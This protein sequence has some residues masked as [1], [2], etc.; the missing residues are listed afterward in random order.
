ML[1]AWWNCICPGVRDVTTRIKELLKRPKIKDMYA[2]G[3]ALKA[4]IDNNPNALQ[5]AIHALLEGSSGYCKI[6][7]ITRNG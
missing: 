2:I 5:D 1:L 3:E 7:G 4:I 6:R